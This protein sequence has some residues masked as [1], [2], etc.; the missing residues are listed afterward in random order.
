MIHCG[1]RTR[2]ELAGAVHTGRQLVLFREGAGRTVA[3]ALRNAAGIRL[4]VSS[5]F[6][7]TAPR[8]DLALGEG[9][10]FERVGVALIHGDPDQARS[11]AR[12]AHAGTLII[13]PERY[14]RVS[15]VQPLSDA[16][17]PLR[18]TAFETWG[19]KATGVLSSPYSGRGVRV[20]I[21]DTGFDLGHPDFAGRAVVSRSFVAGLPVDDANGHGTFCA[22][23]ACGPEQ[24]GDAP[25]Y[26][27]APAAEL[28]VAR[29]LG[30]D[31]SGTDGNVLAG[32]DWAVGHDCAVISI[33]LG[34][35]VYVGDGY[36]EVYEHVAAR[37]LAAGSLLVAPAGN[38]SQRPDNIAPV[39]HPANCPSI[40]AVGAVG[41]SLEVAPFSN[42]GLNPNGG[43][44][45]L[46]APG[47]A[48][49]SAAPR[50]DLYQ[51]GSGT[52]MAT[53][54]VAG[55]A[56]LLAEARPAARGGALRNLLLEA[57]R[58]LPAPVRDVGLG[59]VQAPQ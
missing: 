32:I 29:V 49:V 1:A 10:L 26:G 17:L 53:P 14:V 50:P 34:S 21:L 58:G 42:G 59:L 6:D 44:V 48:I 25:R 40:V 28:H 23:V 15:A 18:D 47:I 51:T 57:F 55:I 46:V 4:A 20:A 8:T 27:V 45:S 36:P 2:R 39:E 22:G 12:R 31:A 41:Q 54:F 9:L 43:E 33:S 13:E 19:L 11:L 7:R 37:A 35:P 5:D 16:A 24:P 30:D 3:E 38:E 52:S 56:A